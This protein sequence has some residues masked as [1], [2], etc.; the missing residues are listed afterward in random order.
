MEGIT[1][2]SIN[3]FTSIHPYS[4]AQILKIEQEQFQFIECLILPRSHG[5]TIC[6]FRITV[7]LCNHGDL[8]VMWSA[9]DLVV[10]QNILLLVKITVT[11]VISI[12]T[13][14]CI[15]TKTLATL[16]ILRITWEVPKAFICKTSAVVIIKQLF[17]CCK[18]IHSIALKFEI[19]PDKDTFI[20]KRKQKIFITHSYCC[21][22]LQCKL[23]KQ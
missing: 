18:Q 15:E 21:D 1:V 11:A 10:K 19:I 23:N 3:F 6:Y 5:S 16:T 2:Y 22:K 9:F 7:T 4:S 14:R 12:C 17:Q 20:L 8:L 13:Y